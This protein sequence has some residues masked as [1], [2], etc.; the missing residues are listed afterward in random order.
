MLNGAFGDLLKAFE[1]DGEPDSPLGG[2]ARG[3]DGFKAY[4]GGPG[5][6][7]PLIHKR[8]E[9]VEDPVEGIDFREV[10]DPEVVDGVL[11]AVERARVHGDA[12]FG[13]QIPGELQVVLPG[14]S[15]DFWEDEESGLGLSG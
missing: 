3:G 15:A 11:L 7:E 6:S 1:A 4:P 12:S 2:G 10:G 5:S 9:L 13:L 14:S 8:L